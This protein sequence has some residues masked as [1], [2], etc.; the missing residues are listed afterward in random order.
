MIETCGIASSFFADAKRA[1]RTW[2]GWREWGQTLVLFALFL[3]FA[4]LVNKVEY[5]FNFSAPDDWG[6]LLAIAALAIAVPA[7]AEEMVF[8]VGFASRSGWLRCGIALVLF[9]VWHPVQVW[10]GLP[11]AQ[12]MFLKPGFLAIVAALGL[13]CTMAYRTSGSIWPPVAIHWA[14]VVV[15]KAVAGG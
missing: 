14:M 1:V 11:M 7:F 2:P 13:V 5:L 15:W 3:A 10:L 6:A 9:V 8:R 12:D 4:A